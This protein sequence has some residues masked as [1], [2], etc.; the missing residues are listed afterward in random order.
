MPDR[1]VTA[2]AG[3]LFAFFVRPFDGD[4]DLLMALAAGCFGDFSVV[5]LYPKRL[6]EAAC[7]EAER[8]PETV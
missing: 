1:A 5:R 2:N 3:S 7:G 6:R 8:V 4:D